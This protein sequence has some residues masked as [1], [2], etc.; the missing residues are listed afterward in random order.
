MIYETPASRIA[1]DE[2]ADVFA[3][4]CNVEKRRYLDLVT[5]DHSY[6]RPDRYNTFHDIGCSETK[7]R[8][9]NFGQY[10]DFYIDLSKVERLMAFPLRSIILV[11]FNDVIAYVDP[12]KTPHYKETI[13]GR[14]DRNDPF[15]IDLVCHYKWSDFIIVKDLR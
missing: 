5:P 15:D 8:H 2:I 11:G 6:S 13:S 14:T 4:T 10:E 1:E 9:I 12:K 3:K 7:K